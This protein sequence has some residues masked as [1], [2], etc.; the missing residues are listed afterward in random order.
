[1][2]YNVTETVNNH[3]ILPEEYWSFKDRTKFLEYMLAS[4]DERF[5]NLDVTLNIY[6]IQDTNIPPRKPGELNVLIC[7]ENCLVHKHYRHYNK[8]GD[9]DDPN[10]QVYIYNHID[11]V[12]ETERFIAIPLL[13]FRMAYLRKYYDTLKPSVERTK[14][15]QKLCLLMTDNKLNAP[16]KTAVYRAVSQL[17]KV[18]SMRD[19][20]SSMRNESLCLTERFLNFINGFRFAIVCENSSAPGYITEKLLQC[21]HGRVIPIYWGS[22]PE[23]YFNEDSFVNIK[24]LHSSDEL[25]KKVKELIVDDDK[26]NA[27]V[28]CPKLKEPEKDYFSELVD[29]IG[30]HT[31]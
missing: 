2:R 8:Y 27:M 19:F 1:M 18:F 25:I 5:A 21:Y 13:W 26:Y 12:I 9:Y 22:R 10:V 23:K 20:K 6:D 31:P 24:E 15:Q 14:E 7:V 17:G 16:V 29:F 28:S 11:S 4:Y 30:K 3:F